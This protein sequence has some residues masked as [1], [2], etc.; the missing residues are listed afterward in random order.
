MPTPSPKRTTEKNPIARPRP[1]VNGLQTIDP[2][3]THEE[4]AARAYE[5]FLA[6]G[7]RHG[8][9]REDWMQ[10]ERELRLGRQ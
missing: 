7:R 3:P 5:L 4:I 2:Q 8:H 9:D 10:A 6:R 1:A